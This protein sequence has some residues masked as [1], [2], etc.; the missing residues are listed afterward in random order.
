MYKNTRMELIMG[1]GV[2]LQNFRRSPII[3]FV[4]PYMEKMYLYNI[5]AFANEHR[6]ST[7][8]TYGITVALA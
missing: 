7:L 5:S 6:L 2:V 8:S 4:A 1:Y 3:L